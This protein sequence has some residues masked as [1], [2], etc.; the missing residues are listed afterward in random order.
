MNDVTDAFDPDWE[1]AVDITRYASGSYVAGKWVE[2]A[3]SIM[4]ITAII[5]RATADDLLILPENLR[6]EE[7]IKIHSR[8]ELQGVSEDDE[9]SADTFSYRAKQWRIY[10]VTDESIGNYHKAIAIRLND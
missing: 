3:T 10:S 6:T 1:I 9:R 7:S 8:S 4:P 5:Q 2:G